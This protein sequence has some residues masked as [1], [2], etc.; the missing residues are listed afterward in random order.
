MQQKGG[1][2]GGWVTGWVVFLAAHFSHGFS[3]NTVKR[4][5]NPTPVEGKVVYPVIF[6]ALAPSNRWLF[7]ISEPS[8]VGTIPLF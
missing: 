4:F 3:V 7:G 1:H 5:R 8:T 2:L 6:K